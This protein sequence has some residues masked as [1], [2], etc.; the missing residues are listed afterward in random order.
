MKWWGES[1][2]AP[3]CIPSNKVPVP[4]G[5]LCFHCQ[6]KIREGEQGFTMPFSGGPEDPEE[7]P[8]HRRC[9]GIAILGK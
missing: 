2:G 9:L 5:D 3:F 8:T 1:W 7:I 4:V 6:D